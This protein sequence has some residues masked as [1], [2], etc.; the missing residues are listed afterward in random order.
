MKTYEDS[1]YEGKISKR[2]SAR[3]SKN[4][5]IFHMNSFI[6]HFVDSAYFFNM[7]IL[8]ETAEK[9]AKRWA[10]DPFGVQKFFARTNK[11]HCLSERFSRTNPNR[12][13]SASLTK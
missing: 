1:V 8:S 11:T 10:K 9:K 5:F 7:E 4:L 2:F 13:V 3:I 6:V 12:P